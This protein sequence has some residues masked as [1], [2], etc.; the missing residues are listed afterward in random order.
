[1]MERELRISL[2]LKEK[3]S[4]KEKNFSTFTLLYKEYF[5]LYEFPFCM[6]CQHETIK[7]CD[8]SQRWPYLI[9]S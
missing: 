5:I 8:D 4:V 3:C 7:S 6:S 2:Y 9:Y 1:M